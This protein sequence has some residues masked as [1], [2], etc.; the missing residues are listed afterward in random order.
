MSDSSGN[1]KP[2]IFTRQATGLIRRLSAPDIFFMNLIWFGGLWSIIY[3]LSYSPLYGG[4]P[5]T[6]LLAAAPGSIAIL[7]VYYWFATS[8]PRSGGDYVYTSRSLMPAL[9]LALNFAGYAW[10][11]WFW[12]GESGFVYTSQGLAPA[13][14]V[15]ATL[16]GQSW[17]SSLATYFTSSINL[18]I[19]G[20]VLI[21]GFTLML[22]YTTRFY[23]RLQNV[24]LAL[25]AIGMIV[26]IVLLATTNTSTF[27]AS[28]DSYGAKVS[29]VTNL[30]Q[31]FT[32]VGS[33][34]AL[35]ENS[36]KYT[37]GLIPLWTTVIFWTFASTFVAG[38]I[39]STKRNSAI[40]VFGSFAFVFVA[41]IASIG[42]A[43]Y[44]L[45]YDFL[46]G[47]GSAYFAYTPNPI[48]VLPNLTLFASIISGNPYLT[49]FL[50]IGIVGSFAFVA[51]VAALQLSRIL[52]SYSF[53]RM[54]PSAISQTSSRGNPTRALIVAAVGGLVFLAFLI[55]PSTAGP[56]FS[57]Y[58]FAAI[59]TLGLA[60]LG[61]CVSA[62]VIPFAK[63]DL[64]N[65]V[66]SMKG[67]LGLPVLSWAGIIGAAYIIFMLYSY[68]SNG[69]FYL[70]TLEPTFVIFIY[71]VL[72]LFV[73]CL[74]W[75]YGVRSYFKSK[76]L[77]LDKI[78]ADIPPE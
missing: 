49:L 2:V 18:F 78:Y 8:M 53:D 51:P 74:V 56:A 59:S 22:M 27:A 11:L 69:T 65:S 12:I 39:K 58:S 61:G 50:M 71:A 5:I 13:M 6:S 37:I 45:G 32:A 4:N 73:G 26:V 23:F 75:Y 30:Y 41:T 21:V 10:T 17:A 43:Y 68:I 64:Y 7:F 28:F 66:A 40:G 16:T 1:V 44:K 14:S 67:K 36:A 24:I 19:W 46:Y 60:L 72:G 38:E 42:L 77:D 15:Y 3:G 63:K 76:Q 48:H 35:P 9:G 55:L 52:F 54:L 29:T 31:N 47:A 20:A 57:L 25:A 34:Y 62:I 70:A 33:A